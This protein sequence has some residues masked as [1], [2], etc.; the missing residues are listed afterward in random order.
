MSI[1]IAF[2]TTLTAL[3][4]IMGVQRRLQAGPQPDPVDPNASRIVATVLKRTVWKPGSKPSKHLAPDKTYYSLEVKV[5]KSERVE[6]NLNSHAI[7]NA[8]MEIFA[9]AKLPEGCVGK[10]IEAIVKLAGESRGKG[11]I[12][13]ISELRVPG[14]PVIIEPSHEPKKRKQ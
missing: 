10:E 8:K 2:L 11:T 12:W 5:A 1:R 9:E 3:F 7:A 14:H 4:A 6:A 13:W